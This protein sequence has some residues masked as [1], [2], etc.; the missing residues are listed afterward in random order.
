MVHPSQSTAYIFNPK[1]FMPQTFFIRCGI[2]LYHYYN[3]L[4]FSRNKYTN[5]RILP[6]LLFL[7]NL[8]LLM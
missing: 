4:E 5:D 7:P 2:F 1:V 6:N 3:D 8:D